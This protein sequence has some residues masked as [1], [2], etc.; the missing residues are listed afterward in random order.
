MLDSSCR[1]QTLALKEKVAGLSNSTM[2][3]VFQR[4]VWEPAV[5]GIEAEVKTLG[6]EVQKMADM[7]ALNQAINQREAGERG[8]PNR[9]TKQV[10]L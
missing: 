9:D 2:D 7:A 10:R 4:M 1:N 3:M 5:A 6:A 8:G